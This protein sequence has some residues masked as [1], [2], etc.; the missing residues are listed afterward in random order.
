MSETELEGPEFERAAKRAR[1]T[2][3]N[4]SPLLRLVREH[5]VRTGGDGKAFDFAVKHYAA[6]TS[7]PANTPQLNLR[8]SLAQVLFEVSPP[9]APHDGSKVT[10]YEAT[11][12]PWNV[13]WT[14][15]VDRAYQQAD[16]ALS[17]LNLTSIFAGERGE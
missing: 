8:E 11:V 7:P 5:F 15:E 1:T 12:S 14:R 6:V 10:W 17:H 9:T 4:P 13:H 2:L 3:D 16:A